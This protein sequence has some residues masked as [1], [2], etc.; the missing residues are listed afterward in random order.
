MDI[1]PWILLSPVPQGKGASTPVERTARIR[2]VEERKNRGWSQRELA[3]ALGTTQHNV[4]RWEAGQTTPGPYFRAKLCTLFGLPALELLFPPGYADTSEKQAGNVVTQLFLDFRRQA[5]QAALT[6]EW[7]GTA[8]DERK[9]LEYRVRLQL[10]SAGRTLRGD[11]QLSATSDE[12]NLG[13]QVV[14]VAGKLAHERFVLLEYTLKDPPEALQFGFILLEFTLDGQA[15]QGGF[16]GY[17]ALV[18]AGVVT[19]TVHLQRQRAR[20][21]LNQVREE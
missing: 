15:L 13:S 17:G 14:T 2:L 12:G 11:G 9:G 1:L 10:R 6:G 18:T 8:R 5:R 19:G 20:T 4:S 16:V 7:C 21:P 3:D